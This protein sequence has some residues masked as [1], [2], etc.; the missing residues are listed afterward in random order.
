ME[1]ENR[2]LLQ[3]SCGKLTSEIPDGQKASY[4]GFAVSEVRE[5]VSPL[6][7]ISLWN[8][9]SI[10][11]L[12]SNLTEPKILLSCALWMQHRAQPH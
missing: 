5:Y 8:A 2:A 1:A 3:Q 7:T 9:V 11:V 10:H 4:L 12:I 6:S